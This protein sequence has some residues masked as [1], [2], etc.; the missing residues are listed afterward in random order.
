MN[1]IFDLEQDFLNCW[2]ITDDLN[3]L[4]EMIMESQELDKDELANFVL[5][6]KTIYHHRFEK[7]WKSFELTC[8]EHHE[9]SHQLRKT[10]ESNNQF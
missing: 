7:A 8:K 3:I 5:G 2:H 9:M 4:Q 6:L 1:H 10:H